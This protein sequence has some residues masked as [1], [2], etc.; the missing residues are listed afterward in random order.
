VRKR[1]ERFAH[2][3]TT[4]SQSNLPESG[5]RLAAKAH[6]ADV[7]DHLPAPRVRKTMAIA[8]SLIDHYDHLLGEVE[9]YLTR[10]AKAH[11]VQTV[12]RLHSVPGIGQSLA[13][14]IR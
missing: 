11:A 12:A 7:A 1:A 2:L 10:R 14:G 4:N 8:V 9:R 13:L 6:R 5:R 3:H